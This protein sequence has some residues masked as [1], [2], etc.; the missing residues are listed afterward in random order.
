MD[1]KIPLGGV[2]TNLSTRAYLNFGHWIERD[3]AQALAA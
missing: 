3:L 1:E 2:E